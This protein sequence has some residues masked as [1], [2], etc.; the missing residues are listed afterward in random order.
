MSDTAQQIL[1]AAAQHMQDR[2]ATYD[3]PEGERSM[4]AAVSAFT[5]ITGVE[6]TEEH[7]WA[8]MLVLK[9]VREN[10]RADAHRDSLEDAVAYASLMAEA[11]L[12][13][14]Q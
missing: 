12:R 14:P 5:A 8:F 2:A 9:L 7:G 1:S 3:K 11:A 13:Q 6:M 4:A 10:A